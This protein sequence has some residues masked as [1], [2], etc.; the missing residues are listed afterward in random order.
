MKKILHRDLKLENILINYDNENDRLNNN[1]IKGK[2]KLIDFGFARHFNR[3]KKELATSALG[4]PMYMDPGILQKYNKMKNFKD[5]TYDEKA[6]IWSLGIICYEIL[7]GKSAYDS[8]TMKELLEK[9]RKGTYYLPNNLSKE[10]ISFLNCM[11]QFDP[12]RR[13]SAKSL[14]RHKFLKNDV[15]KFNKINFDDIKK[16]IKGSK[17]RIN[18]IVNQSIWDI[19]GEGIMDSIMEQSGESDTDEEDEINKEKELYVTKCNSL[20]SSVFQND[21]NL[22]T[23]KSPPKILQK[24]DNLEEMIWKAFNEINFDTISIEPKFTPFIPGMDLKILNVDII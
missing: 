3:E 19:F 13:L 21:N 9:V 7:V 5:Y 14:L 1:I 11:I 20:T 18:S 15:K 22:E 2:I 16:N 24:N 6:D 8:Q 17:I 23:P 4:T 10:A 12:K